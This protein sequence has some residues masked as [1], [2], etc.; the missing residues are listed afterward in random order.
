MLDD[1]HKTPYGDVDFFVYGRPVPQGNMRANKYGYLYYPNE[2]KL[3]AWRELIA[4]HA[5]AAG[6]KRLTGP[7]AVRA[8][9][10]F[11][12]AKSHYVGGKFERG[13][14]P[15]WVDKTFHELAPDSDKLMR[16]IFDALTGVAYR[17]D[18]QGQI[19]NGYKFW[20]DRNRNEKLWEAGGGVRIMLRKL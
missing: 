12:H 4:W 3:K 13:L 10:H 2:K 19:D 9:F 15:E 6:A 7:I 18:K 1:P 14:L 8:Y 16:A 11:P 5:V 17:D 20:I